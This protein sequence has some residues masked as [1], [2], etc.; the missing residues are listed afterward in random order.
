MKKTGLLNKERTKISN[1]QTNCIYDISKETL[2]NIINNA[3]AGLL[4]LN[5]ENKIIFVNDIF[6]NFFQITNSLKNLPVNKLSE[7]ISKSPENFRELSIFV[8]KIN[9]K[10][11][12]NE[13]SE[14]SLTENTNQKKV[15]KIFIVSL[16]NES[17][18]IIMFH[19]ITKEQEIEKLKSDVIATV[20]H[21]LKTPVAAILGYANLL[22]DGIA[23]EINFKQLEYLEKIQIQGERLIK[24]INEIL[25]FS[26]LEAGRMSLYLQSVNLEEV[27]K[28]V[29][30]IVMPFIKERKIEIIT[31]INPDLP[32]IEIDMDKFRQIMLN[33]LNN[34]IK[35]TLPITGKITIQAY[36]L[37][38][39]KVA[40]S[41]KDNGIGIDEKSLEHLFES[42]YRAENIEQ[43]YKGT[44]LGL[45]I[46][47]GLVE[48]HSGNIW[49]ES[50]LNKGSN[51]IFTIP[52]VQKE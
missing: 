11:I 43:N 28:D 31:N 12:D 16:K 33:L 15:Y 13:T 25:D 27:I 40:I 38:K 18:K 50:T 7:L 51:F 9:S 14:L 2:L 49:V 34:A 41:V 32:D 46:T 42:F 6:C 5:S 10:Y 20:S 17:G 23:G 21:E 37:N 30:E 26:R 35:F 24:L 48:L 8:N 45:A 47:K 3:C 1:M 44:G 4:V 52:V 22:E 36:K 39:T 29:L 19:D